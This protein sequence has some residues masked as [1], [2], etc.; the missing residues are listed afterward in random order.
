LKSG[1]ATVLAFEELDEQACGWAFVPEDVVELS[2]QLL[3]VS[4]TE[5]DALR[6]RMAS[7]ISPSALGAAR[8]A[9]RTVASE[10]AIAKRSLASLSLCIEEYAKLHLPQ[11]ISSP[12]EIARV[13]NG[14]RLLVEFE[15]D[16]PLH[17]FTPDVLRHFRDTHLARM[18]ANENQV[19]QRFG[20]KSMSESTRAL[21]IVE[22]P[23]MSPGERELRM[24]WLSRMF[25]WFHAQKWIAD[26]P[27]TGLRGESVLTKV[28][29]KQFASSRKVRQEFSSEEL[30]RIFTAPVYQ[31]ASW[32]ATRAGTFRTFQPFHYWL[33]L[34]GHFTGARIGELCQLHLDDVKC[35]DGFW[36]V[37]INECTK[38]KS[39]KNGWSA[40]RVPLHPRLVELG[41][42]SWCN[43]LRQEGYRRLFPELSWNETNRYA[44]EPIRAMSQFFV[45]LGMPRDGTKVFH[46]FRRVEQSLAEA[47]RNARHHAEAHDGA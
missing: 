17:Q 18:P 19:R 23:L 9:M 39:L 13:R 38:D 47:F 32:Q 29:R 44:K 7:A 43:Q 40:R 21:D 36:F 15:G 12:K 26:D 10:A 46:S 25:G 34:L 24:Q 42:I 11:S 1:H 3:E 2:D 30:T 14:L 5:V 31:V 27:C 16:Q 8:D 4:A 20:T 6:R 35:H 45:K 33:P 41:L 28:E 22:W 37:D